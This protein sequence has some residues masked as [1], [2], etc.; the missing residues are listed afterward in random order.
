MTPPFPIV[1]NRKG[2]AAIGLLTVA[3]LAGA[4]IFFWGYQAAQTPFRPDATNDS[5]MQFVTVER[6]QSAR[7]TAQALQDRGIVASAE[8]LLW[9]GRLTRDWDRKKAGEYALSPSMTPLQ[10]LEV[11]A[12]GVSVGFMITL[13][14]GQNI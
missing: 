5:D 10:I 8:Q 6:G 4:G 2:S 7:Q 12:R 1:L 9:L 13:R 14:E 3:A 11:L